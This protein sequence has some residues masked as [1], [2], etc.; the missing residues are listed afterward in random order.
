MRAGL[1]LLH[2]PS[3]ASSSPQ[4]TGQPCG[5]CQCALVNAVALRLQQSGAILSSE[6]YTANAVK[7]LAD[8]MGS[9]MRSFSLQLQNADVNITQ[10]G[11]M[12]VCVPDVRAVTECLA[13]PGDAATSS[14]TQPAPG[15]K[16]EGSSE[17][18]ANHPLRFMD[19]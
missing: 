15:N 10:L 6:M 5:P 17:C 16:T 11:S 18:V 2:V 3:A 9:C 19:W 8:T 13:Q 12:D 14:A 4:A 7:T 1:L